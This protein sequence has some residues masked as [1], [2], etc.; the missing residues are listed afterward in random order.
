[1]IDVNKILKKKKWSG[2]DAG[3][4]RI[5]VMAD[6]R[7]QLAEGNMNPTPMIPY[8]D[9]NYIISTITDQKELDVLEGYTAFCNWVDSYIPAVSSMEQLAQGRYMYIHGL[10][11]NAIIAENALSY[12]ERLPVIMTQEQYNRERKTN[13]PQLLVGSF[14]LKELILY[15]A[16][17]LLKDL[18]ANPHRQNVLKP[19]RKKYLSE[20]VQSG[21]IL[22]NY[23][24]ITG[25]GYYLLSDGRRSDQ[26][27]TREWKAFS[28]SA[29]NLINELAKSGRLRFDIDGLEAEK[30]VRKMFLA[31]EN[32][33]RD[34]EQDKTLPFLWV[35][36]DTAPETLSKWDAFESDLF[37]YDLSAE[38]LEKEFPDITAATIRAI[39]D[40]DY[41]DTWLSDVPV[42][43]WEDM[44][45]H[46]FSYRELYD[47][48]FFGFREEKDFDAAAQNTGNRGNIFGLAILQQNPSLDLSIGVDKEGNYSCPSTY[49]K[50]DLNGLGAFFDETPNSEIMK[51]RV[52]RSKEEF[53][54]AAYYEFAYNWI[55]RFTM[56]MIGQED[57]TG[58]IIREQNIKDMIYNMTT[59]YNTLVAQITMAQYPQE[60]KQK[61]L[62][63]LE[64]VFKPITLQEVDPPERNME[65]VE[66]MIREDLRCFSSNELPNALMRGYPLK[67]EERNG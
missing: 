30:A 15:A 33:L 45:Q 23:N 29:S 41:F 37:L 6:L 20:S 24:R 48:D 47:L 58:M 31:K 40:Q 62:A 19:V 67:R 53:R 14:S 46:S 44:D 36:D 35:T 13:L 26:M 12:I 49:E 9:I 5:A 57:L 52:L 1:M 66:G 16:N 51:Q 4:L 7:R 28:E 11:E 17:A 63:V 25:N 56:G 34:G 32:I 50:F 3:L 39:D 61:K 22:E 10:E 64:E 65:I 27:T 21:I 59:S 2:K 38:E 18:K 42:K 43:E 60:Q 54:N 55:M 8:A